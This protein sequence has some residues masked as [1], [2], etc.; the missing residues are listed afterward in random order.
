MA[1]RARTWQTRPGTPGDTGA[2]QEL[3]TTVFGVDRGALHH[4]WKFEDNPAG[5]QVLAVAEDEGRLVGQ[6]ALWPMRLRLGDEVVQAAQS[7]DTMTHP[8]YRGQGMFTVLAKAA[9]DYA[10]ERGIEV[11]FGFP[12]TASYPGFVRKLDWDHVGDVGQYTRV[13]RPSR[14]PRVPGWAGAPADLA[15]RLLPAGGAA[16]RARRIDPDP[17]LLSRLAGPSTERM[18][19]SVERDQTYAAWR[20]HHASGREYR[21]LAVDDR[22]L[23]IWGRDAASGRAL[24]SELLATTS[25]DARAVLAAVIEDSRAAGCSELA[26]TVH[27]PG[28]SPVLPRAGFVRRSGLPLVVRKLTTRVMPVNVHTFDA[29]QV[30]GADV[31]TY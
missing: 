15:A 2:L 8:D 22:A 11:L 7:L 18:S 1:D 25:A 9:M 20:Y 26:A 3:F 4:R 27:R 14:H 24:L 31:D 19:V 10:Q 6:Y 29:W 28:Q 13:L 5:P 17:A 21:W 30:F 23:A 12:N 16:S